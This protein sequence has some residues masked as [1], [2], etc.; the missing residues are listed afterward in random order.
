MDGRF[1]HLTGTDVLTYTWIIPPDG[2]IAVGELAVITDERT[3]T[4]YFARIT[5]MKHDLDTSGLLVTGL[6][7][8]CISLDGVFRKP[9]TIPP[10]RSPVRPL[11][12]E[13]HALLRRFMGEL[14]VGFMMSGNKK[15]EDLPVGIPSSVLN[16]HLG[17]FATTGM[18]KSNLMKVFCASAISTRK[19]GILLTDPHGEY[20]TGQ[21]GDPDSRGL[22]HHP[23][24]LE[25]LSVFTIRS[26]ETALGYRMK[27]LRIGHKDLSIADLGLVFDL[28][29]AQYEVVNLLM[30][31][32][33][34]EVIDFFINEDVESLPSHL[35][36]TAY[37][38]N[39]QDIA[40][41]VR[42]A[43]PDALRLVQR[44]IRTLLDL[45]SLFVDPSASSLPDIMTALDEKKVV[46]IDIPG[47][48]DAAE[49]F[50]LSAISRAI[51]RDR[52]R[53]FIEL[54]SGAARGTVLISIEEAQRVLSQ[55]SEKTGI[56][57]E[58]AM[59]GRKFGVGLG[60]ITQQ[61]KNIDQRV[62]AQMN[63]LFVMGLADRHD[64][65]IIA[66]SAKHDLRVLDTE[67]QTLD[68]GDAVI[69]TVGIPFPVS[70]HI[71]YFEEYLDFLWESAA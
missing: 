10:L 1:H 29:P 45:T 30:P 27:P 63:T 24:A 65:E 61:P 53:R 66:S 39:H 55:R 59:E 44:Q 48:S 68:R 2:M 18:G 56:F 5:G 46:L 51:F 21:P 67:I 15:V 7:I 4:R 58:I 11:D 13:E 12:A 52:Q 34:H 71:H 17:V 25:G 41:R 38:G 69:S 50:I 70:C 35:R 62:L 6:P 54:G 28:T 36:T 40:Q 20:A 47:M 22:V 42:S 60:V 14:E 43:P 23:R 8:G 37:I 49:L 64:R 57:R 31:F 26:E 9:R 16:Q 3:K 33:T 19:A 32:S